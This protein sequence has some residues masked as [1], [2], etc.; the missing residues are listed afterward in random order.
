M[1]ESVKEISSFFLKNKS[2]FQNNRLF[3]SLHQTGL[4]SGNFLLSANLNQQQNLENKN[5]F[6]LLGVIKN[7]HSYDNKDIFEMKFKN[8]IIF[9]SIIERLIFISRSKALV[10]DV[11]RQSI[12]EEKLVNNSSFEKIRK[13]INNRSEINLFYNLN[14]LIEFS[15]IYTKNKVKSHALI[16]FSNW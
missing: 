12:S 5:V 13:T 15:S 7:V 9:G 8:D 3:I 10:E 14:N 11:I 2:I 1:E 6:E 4:N 16:N